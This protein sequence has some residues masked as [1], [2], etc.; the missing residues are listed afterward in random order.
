MRV[1]LFGI[2]L[3][4]SLMLRA[5]PASVRFN[6]ELKANVVVTRVT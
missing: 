2:A 1:L 6:N 5:Q 3:V 4:G